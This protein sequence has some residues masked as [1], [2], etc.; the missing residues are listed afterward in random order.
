MLWAEKISGIKD[1]GMKEMNIVLV[2]KQQ[3]NTGR[4]LVGRVQSD[5]R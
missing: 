2:E 5:G 1:V 4:A 3:R